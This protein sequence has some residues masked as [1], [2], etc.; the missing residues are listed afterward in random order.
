MLIPVLFL[1]LGTFV[2]FEGS[3]YYM[4][5]SPLRSPEPRVYRDTILCHE[6]VEEP[7]DEK[8]N[9]EAQIEEYQQENYLFRSQIEQLE[10]DE[11]E[12]NSRVPVLLI[13]IGLLVALLIIVVVWFI[14][15]QREL[16]RISNSQPVEVSEKSPVELKCFIAGSK[17]LQRERDA[18]R[19]VISIMYNKWSHKNFRILAY[20][21]EDFDK[22]IVEG[23]H[24]S[25][26]NQFISSEADWA[27][28]VIDGQVGGITLEEFRHAMTAFKENGKPKILALA[29]I[30]SQDNANVFAIKNEICKEQQYW[31]DYSDIDS[32]KHIFEITLNWDLIN[33]YM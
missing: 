8:N 32:L 6:P 19:S 18:L 1:V 15:K 27:I 16:K 22:A 2:V 31:T 28:F 30:G 33:L 29:K 20:T 12:L 9:L 21:F 26:Y 14:V 23:G 7:V 5:P 25:K 13:A 10:E 24:Q 11:K 3:R 4:S 17:A